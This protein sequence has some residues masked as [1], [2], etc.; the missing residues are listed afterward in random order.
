MTN[1]L[2][3]EYTII[4]IIVYFSHFLF[5]FVLAHARVKHLETLPQLALVI[6]L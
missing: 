5:R 3:N 4:I 6:D 1:V 2:Q